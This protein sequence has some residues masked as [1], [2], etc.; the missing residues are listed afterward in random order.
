MR[1][2]L[3]N[4]QD[5]IA[6]LPTGGGKSAAFEVPLLVEEMQTILIVPFV[7]LMKDIMQ[8]VKKIGIR[9]YQWNAKVPWPTLG[10]GNLV[11]VI[12]ESAVGKSFKE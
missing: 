11:V 12:Y 5:V 8:R 1:T 10:E 9:P 7:S 4:N 6:V 2:V 3:D